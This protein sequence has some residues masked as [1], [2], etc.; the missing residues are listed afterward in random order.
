MGCRATQ[1][2]LT[3]AFAAAAGLHGARALDAIN[4]TDTQIRWTAGF[5]ENGVGPIDRLRIDW[6][7]GTTFAAPFFM[8]F[9]VQP[10]DAPT[11][12]PGGWSI[13][14]GSLPEA[15]AV[16][17]T[18]AN[19]LTFEVVFSRP[20]TDPLR[21]LFRAWQGETLRDLTRVDWSGARWDFALVG[22]C[23]VGTDCRLT[24]ETECADLGGRFQGAG[25]DCSPTL[26]LEATPTE[27]SSWGRVKSLY[28]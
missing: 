5:S 8:N 3:A 1:L 7:A 4:D 26:C 13:A 17:P 10:P 12:D 27:R 19:S 14:F 11:V 9:D 18:P 22:A 28:R 2:I 15:S 25:V 23:C 24:T 6:V 20:Q 21:F 16:A